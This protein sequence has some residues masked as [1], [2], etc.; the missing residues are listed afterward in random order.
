MSS[1]TP[2]SWVKMT[3][4]NWTKRLLRLAIST[5]KVEALSNR[6]DEIL[7]ML[8]ITET[9]VR[10]IQTDEFCTPHDDVSEQTCYRKIAAII[11][12]L[13]EGHSFDIKEYQW[14]LDT[15]GH[16]AFKKVSLE[17][18]MTHQTKNIRLNKGILSQL[19]QLPVD[20]DTYTMAMDWAG[21]RGYIYVIVK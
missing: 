12:I 21:A 3:R 17:A 13:L 10:H 15:L 9:V 7:A 19:L 1:R 4:R 18:C 8:D 16:L 2:S 14:V 6:E 11:D 5:R 20:A